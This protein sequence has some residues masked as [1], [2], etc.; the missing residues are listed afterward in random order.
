MK[1][2]SS[3]DVSYQLYQLGREAMEQRNLAVAVAL[4]RSSSELCPHFKTFE[5]L[6]ECL[7]ELPDRL[8]EAVVFLAAAAG[9]G[10]KSSRSFFLLARA[11]SLQ[12]NVQSAI[13]KLAI[14]IEMQPEYKAAV[15]LRDELRSRLHE[16]GE[17][18]G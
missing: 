7:L 9:L 5:L 12:G 8:S 16:N 18:R 1:P 4:F 17:A 2:S 14:A 11:L 15:Q 3:L 10:N 13:E 6:G